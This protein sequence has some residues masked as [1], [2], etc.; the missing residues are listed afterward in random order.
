MRFLDFETFERNAALDPHWKSYRL[1]WTY[2]ALA[3]EMARGLNLKSA[4][5]VLEIGTGGAQVV[6][7]SRTMD[8]PA[9]KIPPWGRP[10]IEHDIMTLP[11]PI[12]DR[13]FD[14]LVALRVW[15]HLHPLQA[16]CLREARRVAKYVIICCPEKKDAVGVHITEQQFTDWNGRP[17]LQVEHTNGWGTVYLFGESE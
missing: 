2:H 3:I 8:A 11:W 12:E 7:G 13:K 14:L 10:N 16:E 5:R 15:H 17:P 9:D 1:R 6:I 4:R